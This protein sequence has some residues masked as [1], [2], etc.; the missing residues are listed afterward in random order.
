MKNT[1][2]EL[3]NEYRSKRISLLP[4]EEFLMNEQILSNL[5]T[6]DWGKVN[7]CHIFLPIAKFHE[8]N[9]FLFISYL[10]DFYPEINIV[11]SKSEL[12]T[13]QMQHYLYDENL[14]FI[15]NQWGILDPESGLSIDE[16]LLDVILI[17]LLISDQHGN[18][19]GYGKGYYDRFLSLCRQDVLKVGVSFFKPIECVED[20]DQHDIPIDVCIT[21]L[22][23]EYYKK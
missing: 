5:K 9:T 4:E 10:R 8:P 15:K 23:V 18:R 13:N 7:Y 1:K 6:L 14:I 2:A 17:P 11:V 20:V 21:P 22:G 19:V 16:K 3:R 12:K